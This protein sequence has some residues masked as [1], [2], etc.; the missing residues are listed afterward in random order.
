MRIAVLGLGG[1][2]TAAARCLAAAG[3]QVVGFE[4]FRLDHDRGSSYGGSRIIRKVYPD[5]L[6]AALMQRAYPLWEN[7][8]RESGDSLLLRC[9]GLFLGPETHADMAATEAALTAVGVPFERLGAAAAARRFPEFRL[10]AEEYALFEPESGL[11][12]ASACVM[13][14][15]RGARAAGAE[16][17][18]EVR[19]RAL[20]PLSAG[21]RVHSAAGVETFD[22]LVVTAG[23][24]TA[25][26][27]APWAD[28]PLTVTRQQYAH[29]AVTRSADFAPDRF[30]VWIDMAELYYGFPE[31]GE[32]PG[33][34]AAL[35][36]PG[37][38][39]DPEDPDRTPDPAENERLRVYCRR[40]LPGAAGAVT[41]AK[42]C[43][44]TMTP[45]EDFVLDT[46]PGE[47]RVVVV[48]GLSGHGFKFTV[49][50]GRLAADLAVHGTTDADLS[51]F[52]LARFGG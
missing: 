42:V 14:N 29:F 11:L 4:Q 5:P 34:K 31:H 6:Y 43:L 7:L 38:P 46:L 16:L 33:A 18:E 9:G 19:L 36:V 12:Q 50:L 51:R 10:R 17:R 21:V 8:E 30:P 35:H 15:A 48:A 41:F 52:R 2:G 45:D 24:W 20:E 49:L 1:V 13:A 32:V 39:L 28:L 23:P 26:L 37:P 22:R 40:R 3:H 27:L 25:P 47:P 44:Y